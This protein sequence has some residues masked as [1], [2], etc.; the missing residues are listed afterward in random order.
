M[1]TWLTHLRVADAL[2]RRLEPC[3]TIFLVGNL[4]P[5]SSKFVRDG[6]DPPTA[7]THHTLTDKSECDY[8]G[9]A[10]KYVD[11]SEGKRR[12]F[13]VGY[14]CHLMTDVLWSR[15]IC[16]PCEKRFAEQFSKDEK[17]FYRRIK[18]NWHA[19]DFDYLH[20]H[21]KYAP[22]EEIRNFGRLP[23][24]LLDYLPNRMIE[25]KIGFITRYYDADREY[26]T[27]YSYLTCAET[28]QFVQEAAMEIE[29]ELLKRGYAQRRSP[30]DN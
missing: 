28:E 20:Q 11:N 8:D 23:H 19:V 1:A 12:I 14:F 9:F 5:D 16:I 17:A 3:G 26:D 30:N 10:K 18:Q 4:A 7:V 22:I 21:P 15:R 25:Y 6:F 24:G 27:D 13:Y 2:R 29:R